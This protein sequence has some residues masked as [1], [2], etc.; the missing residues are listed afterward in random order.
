MTPK[1]ENKN[2]KMESFIDFHYEKLN[3]QDENDLGFDDFMRQHQSMINHQE[4]VRHNTLLNFEQLVNTYDYL[5][6]DQIR[7][8][9]Y[10]DNL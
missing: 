7:N 3:E 1:N 2:R 10:L 9:F 4:G 5:E 6:D 8:Q